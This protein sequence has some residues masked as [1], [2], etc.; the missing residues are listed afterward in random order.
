M[1]NEARSFGLIAR[2]MHGMPYT[3]A[4]VQFAPRD[5]IISERGRN[6]HQAK[7]RQEKS[8]NWTREN[9]RKAW[10]IL[11]SVQRQDEEK[12]CPFE[13]RNSSL[14]RPCSTVVPREPQLQ[15]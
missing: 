13:R 14:G 3:T 1:A 9:W 2:R 7:S 11:F 12:F 4:Q 8:R 6:I 15:N 5:K 10:K